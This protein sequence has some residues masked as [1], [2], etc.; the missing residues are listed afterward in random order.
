MNTPPH[1]RRDDLEPEDLGYLRA[2]SLFGPES[3]A[4][5]SIRYIEVEPG[6]RTPTIIHDHAREVVMVLGGEGTFHVGGVDR[7][8]REGDFVHVPPGT[9]HFLRTDESSVR[10]VAVESPPVYQGGDFRVVEEA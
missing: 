2:W 6:T 1:V 5:F 3:A 7:V 10:F 9:P 4:D 8:C